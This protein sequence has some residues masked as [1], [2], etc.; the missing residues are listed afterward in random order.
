MDI[1]DKALL[2]G[3]GL[4]AL[5]FLTRKDSAGTSALSN[6]AGA[7]GSA[8]GA[9]I[10]QAVISA[11]SAAAGSYYQ[12]S[13]NQGFNIGESV[14]QTIRAATTGTTAPAVVSLPPET[15]TLTP[16][17][18]EAAFNDAYRQATDPLWNVPILGNI[19]AAWHNLLV[20]APE[21]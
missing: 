10:P 7:A 9:A 6:V 8:V 2:V 4:A 20:G 15:L 16:A 3:G 5:Y 11:A 17:Q 14:G 1:G 13:Y 19:S 12:E 18:Q 21:W